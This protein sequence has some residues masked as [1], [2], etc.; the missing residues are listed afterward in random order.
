[1]FLPDLRV[2][3]QIPGIICAQTERAVR[4]PEVGFVEAPPDG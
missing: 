4:Y 2:S 1:M 3:L